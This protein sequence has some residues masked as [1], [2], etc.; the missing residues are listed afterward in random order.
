MPKLLLA[1][2]IQAPETVGSFLAAAD[3]R[4]KDAEALEAAGRRLGAVYLYGYAAE[5]LI[6]SAY[7]RVVR[8]AS[9]LPMAAPITHAD[10]S[11]WLPSLRAF[12][13]AP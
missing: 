10:R 7:F 5:M 13:T 3:Q 12:R 2:S 8:S 4:F 9:G 1:R 11:I 6:K